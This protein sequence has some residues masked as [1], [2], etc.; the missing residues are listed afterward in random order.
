MSNLGLNPSFTS[1]IIN[2]K[3][4]FQNIAKHVSSLLR[5]YIHRFK[6]FILFIYLFWVLSFI[7]GFLCRFS[8]DGIFRSN[9]PPHPP[10]SNTPREYCTPYY[11]NT[12]CNPALHAGNLSESRQWG[13]AHWHGG[14]GETTRR[15]WESSHEEHLHNSIILP[16]INPFNSFFIPKHLH[17]MKLPY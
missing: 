15:G 3:I 1:F 14:G 9:Q 16:S 12:V 13:T 2:T 10:S 17:C 8:V 6:L 11:C 4:W 5:M 7:F